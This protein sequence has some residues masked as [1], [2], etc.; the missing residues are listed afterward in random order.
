MS[1]RGLL[2]K[3]HRRVEPLRIEAADVPFGADLTVLLRWFRRLAEAQ[4]AHGGD[5]RSVVDGIRPFTQRIWAR[6]PPASKRRFL[7]HARAWWDVHRHRMAPEVDRRIG[8]AMAAGAL[9]IIA[10]KI[11]AVEPNGQGALVRYRRRGESTEQIMQV[12]KI[13]ECTGIVKNPLHTSNP[14]LR[15]LLDQGLARIDPL[16]IGIDVTAGCALVNRF[17]LH[18]AATVWISSA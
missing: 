10:G 3:P 7:E 2:P 18:S 5:W 15:S 17:P 8:S 16:R 14:A 4:M 1:R 13:V 11:C 9:T 6:L 12:A